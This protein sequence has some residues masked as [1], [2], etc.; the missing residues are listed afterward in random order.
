MIDKKGM[1]YVT[2]L[3]IL[4]VMAVGALLVGTFS[5]YAG[6]AERL[7]VDFSWD[8]LSR[9]R[10]ELQIGNRFLIKESDCL[11][12]ELSDECHLDSHGMDIVCYDSSQ[13]VTDGD[14]EGS[15]ECEE[16]QLP[17]GIRNICVFP[18]NTQ[19][20]E[21]VCKTHYQGHCSEL[22]EGDLEGRY[23]CISDEE[24]DTHRFSLSCTNFE[25]RHIENNDI[26]DVDRTFVRLNFT[27]LYSGI[28]PSR[29]RFEVWLE[30][31]SEIGESGISG[32]RLIGLKQLGMVP[33]HF[34]GVETFLLN[35]Y[36][37]EEKTNITINMRAIDDEE[38]RTYHMDENRE[39]EGGYR[40]DNLE[41]TVMPPEKDIDVYVDILE[42]Y[43]EFEYPDLRFIAG[44]RGEDVPVLCPEAY[45]YLVLPGCEQQG[46]GETALSVDIISTVLEDWVDEEEGFVPAFRTKVNITNN[47]G[48]N[49]TWQEA[50]QVYLDFTD[51]IFEYIPNRCVG[52]IAV[53]NMDGGRKDIN[54]SYEDYDDDKCIGAHLEFVIN[55]SEDN[56]FEKG[57]TREYY[58][59][60]G[61]SLGGSIPMS[62]KQYYYNETFDDF[63]DKRN[64][65]RRMSVENEE[66][67]LA[68]ISDFMHFISVNRFRR[69]NPN[70]EEIM[71]IHDAAHTNPTGPSWSHI[72]SAT[73]DSEENIY[74][75]DEYDYFEDYRV[76]VFI[77]KLDPFGNELY[78]RRL[79]YGA[80]VMNTF[81]SEDISNTIV[82]SSD[83]EMYAASW[84]YEN[85]HPRIYHLELPGD[86][87]SIVNMNRCSF[88]DID[89]RINSIV[90]HNS[91]IYFT[92]QNKLYSISIEPD[93]TLDCSYSVVKEFNEN[94]IIDI[95]PNNEF[96]YIVKTD[97][98]KVQ[99]MS[100]EDEE[101]DGDWEVNLNE[102]E[103]EIQKISVSNRYL[104][105]SNQSTKLTSGMEVNDEILFNLHRLDLEGKEIYWY[106]ELFPESRFGFF[107]AE[108]TIPLYEEFVYFVSGGDLKRM[109][110]DTFEIDEEWKIDVGIGVEEILVRDP[111]TLEE[112]KIIHV[113]SGSRIGAYNESNLEQIWQQ[114]VSTIDYMAISP[115][116]DLFVA[117]ADS[118]RVFNSTGD[119]IAFGNISS[120]I[121]IGNGKD[122]GGTNLK[123]INPTSIYFPK[124]FNPPINNVFYIGGYSSRF[125][126]MTE[127]IDGFILKALYFKSDG[128][129]EIDVAYEN[130]IDWA[131]K[132]PN[133]GPVVGIIEEERDKFLVASYDNS[134][135]KYTTAKIDLTEV[136]DPWCIP[137]FCTEICSSCDSFF[138]HFCNITVA[139]E[140]INKISN[141][142]LTPDGNFYFTGYESREPSD[143]P[144]LAVNDM[145]LSFID[146]L[147]LSD[148]SKIYF[149]SF[150]DGFLSGDSDHLF[151]FAKV[152]GQNNYY[153]IKQDKQDLSVVYNYLEWEN[154]EIVAMALGRS[155][156]DFVRE[157]YFETEGNYVSETIEF[158][159]ALA[160]DKITWDVELNEG[161]INISFKIPNQEGSMDWL[162]FSMNETDE[163]KIDDLIASKFKFNLTFER[164]LSHKTTPRLFNISIHPAEP[165]LIGEHLKYFETRCIEIEIDFD[166]DMSDGTYY[167]WEITVGNGDK[168]LIVSSALTDEHVVR[169]R[170]INYSNNLLLF[171]ETPA[172]YYFI[173]D[174]ICSKAEE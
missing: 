49:I 140:E 162:E 134:A 63:F 96:L 85:N 13:C 8:A 172:P 47:I 28:V 83:G 171:N 3:L 137:V 77:R 91:E 32:S 111:K 40:F 10:G 128:S 103:I 168:Y 56:K 20:N 57:E 144:I 18:E 79:N 81:S 148:G 11:V 41:F 88:T 22:E 102:E 65:S 147:K 130:G 118:I 53:E 66:L 104:Y 50:V 120:S 99:R 122:I 27:Y 30:D 155:I 70:A 67:K 51:E 143:R 45:V 78:N 133:S 174:P 9:D 129:I 107:A 114:D 119:E 164:G 153:L 135:N 173:G 97:G 156:I 37:Y 154:S 163:I 15:M 68:Q 126:G 115:H 145:I 74:L 86:T 142:K 76:D 141:V 59:Y 25:R 125:D 136:S 46:G 109:Y 151:A 170:E 48:E 36:E 52:E 71:S 69:Y 92:V 150:E 84:Y 19:C 2:F 149:E 94:I 1:T 73:I 105:F 138:S 35:F 121:N 17:I 152:R 60:Y 169:Y 6:L 21:N 159:Y 165:R 117:T 75:I 39:K 127:S 89:G 98:S 113:R 29:L 112:D 87:T 146:A 58:V 31:E 24:I 100:V 26:V 166:I 23:F 38:T 44:I 12:F 54:L 82:V 167:S 131:I 33:F 43:E 90:Y 93:G 55:A 161:N 5:A 160:W 123:N 14:C 108:V 132:I 80:H 72:V 42:H 139:E 61:T 4:G 157:G 124:T 95:C 106:W 16:I 34:E 7:G 64:D 62:L 101:M 116:G 158:D 110:V